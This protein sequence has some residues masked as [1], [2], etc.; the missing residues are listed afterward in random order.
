[1][2]FR[3][4][5]NRLFQRLYAKETTPERIQTAARRA[6]LPSVLALAKQPEKIAAFWR[7]FDEEP[8]P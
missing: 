2:T 5:M 1:M 6:G 4:L 8:S 7:E 3:D